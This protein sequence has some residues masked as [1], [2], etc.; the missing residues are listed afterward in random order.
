VVRGILRYGLLTNHD[1]A[2]KVCDEEDRLAI[3]KG[4]PTEFYAIAQSCWPEEPE[5]RPVS[6]ILP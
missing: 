5:K 3:P 1:V 2:E 6:L 4:V